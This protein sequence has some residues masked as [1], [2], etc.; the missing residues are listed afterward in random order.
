MKRV[1]SVV[2]VVF[3]LLVTGSL[4]AAGGASEG[5]LVA[6]GDAAYRK[7]DNK[8]AL[9]FY[10]KALET[11]PKNYEAAWKLARAHVDVGEKLA[12]KKERR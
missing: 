1:I 3:I 9:E 2:M 4:H 7:F 12:D 8:D 6:K 5:T 11:D 10:R